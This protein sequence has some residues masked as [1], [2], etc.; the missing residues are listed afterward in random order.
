[1]R[2][3]KMFFGIALVGLL[4][5]FVIRVALVAFV[6]AAVM[7]I[8][9]AIFRRVKDFITYDRYGNHYIPKYEYKQIHHNRM[10]EV[11]PLFYGVQVTPRTPAK[12][13]RFIDAI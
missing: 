13:I 9:Y 8:T 6:I 3:F 4:F 10:N 12:N 11:E 7:S 2:P 5:L 1:M